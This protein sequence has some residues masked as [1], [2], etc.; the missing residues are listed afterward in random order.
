[1]R[2]RQ[3]RRC[4]SCRLDWEIET[5]GQL[6]CV[7]CKK[8]RL[9]RVVESVAKPTKPRQFQG[10][11]GGKTETKGNCSVSLPVSR[12][13]SR[14]GT[15]CQESRGTQVRFQKEAG[16]LDTCGAEKEAAGSK[17]EMRCCKELEPYISPA[18]ASFPTTPSDIS[19]SETLHSQP[20]HEV[21]TLRTQ[22]LQ[23]LS[24]QDSLYQEIHRITLFLESEKLRWL[25][26]IK[27]LKDE[28]ML[29]VEALKRAYEEKVKMTQSS[30]LTTEYNQLIATCDREKAELRVSLE[31]QYRTSLAL[32]KEQLKRQYDLENE[33]LRNELVKKAEEEKSFVHQELVQRLARQES[34]VKEEARLETEESW[35]RERRLYEER[36]Q[37]RIGNIRSEYERKL[38]ELQEQS[39]EM[40]R[41]IATLK[42]KR[43][44]LEEAEVNLRPLQRVLCYRCNALV[45]ISALLDGKLDRYRGLQ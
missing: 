25:D 40:K 17:L 38:R 15:P 9:E 34:R 19:S 16:R 28:H 32:I 24:Y 1:M 41:E 44:V 42:V 11:K 29:E 30:F 43:P 23:A 21:Q 8:E 26:Q 4:L 45:Q 6:Q 3:S 39:G 20:L 33:K 35:N 13:L 22:L 12:A 31:D 10:K 37:D 36:M 7:N 5:T 2:A 18:P 27:R 14:V